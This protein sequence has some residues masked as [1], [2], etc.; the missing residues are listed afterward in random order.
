METRITYEQLLYLIEKQGIAP[1]GNI[2]PSADFRR[3]LHYSIHDLFALAQLL[4][5]HFFIRL[6]RQQV[7]E[8]T[9]LKET[10][11]TCN[12]VPVPIHLVNSEY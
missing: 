11:L 9:T 8:L 10:L 3:N 1:K 5:N 2:W 7:S 12:Q 6:T 4:E